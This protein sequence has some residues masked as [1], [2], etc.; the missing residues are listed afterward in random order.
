MRDQRAPRRRGVAAP[1][2]SC[3]GRRDRR[4]SARASEPR[5]PA[6]GSMGH[7]GAPS[8]A[9][10]ASTPGTAPVPM[11]AR[12]AAPAGAPGV[13]GQ[14]GQ[15]HAEGIAE[16]LPPDRAPRSAVDRD[17]L[18]QRQ[19]AL[20]RSPRGSAGTTRPP[21]RGR[22]GARCAAAVGQ[23][24]ARRTRPAR[25]RPT[26]ACARPGDRAGGEDRRHPAG[27]GRALGVQHSTG[28]PGR[29]RQLPDPLL[30]RAGQGGPEGEVAVAPDVMGVDEPRVE[31]RPSSGI[32]RL[33]AVPSIRHA[34][35]GSVTPAA[36]VEAAKSAPPTTTGIALAPGPSPARRRGR[37]PAGHGVGRPGSRAARPRDPTRAH[38]G[39]PAA[40]ARVVERRAQRRRRVVGDA[41]AGQPEHR[42][43]VGLENRGRGAQRS[44]S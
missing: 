38:S 16:D 33:P 24:R 12:S 11:P 20:A 8:P 40:G 32:T 27:R 42:I 7:H 18:A 22:R 13:L 31:R 19:P 43:A 23:R 35:P 1:A 14:V 3:H 26:P 37:D 2:R 4:A 39:R 15:R 34:S 44:G 29:Q 21:P 6:S 17:D 9:P 30:H 10:A 5:A 25:P 36:S 41:G 28:T